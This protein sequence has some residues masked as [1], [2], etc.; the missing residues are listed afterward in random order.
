[1]HVHLL[2]KLETKSV[3]KNREMDNYSISYSKEDYASIIINNEY[4]NDFVHIFYSLQSLFY[5]VSFDDTKKTTYKIFKV[6]W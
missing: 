4:N 3:P 1:M 5:N 6:K 2:E